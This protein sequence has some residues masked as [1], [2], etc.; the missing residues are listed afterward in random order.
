[1]AQPKCPNCSR[2]FV[3]RVALV[4]TAEMLLGFLYVYPFK[5]QLC[6][7]RFRMPQWGVR[8]VR[9]PEDQRDYDRM[10]ASFPLTFHT[11]NMSGQGAA[12]NISMGGCSFSTSTPLA[13]GMVLRMGLHV[14][15]DLPAVLVD[16]AAVRYVHERTVGIEFLQ[17]Q[18]SERE[19]LQL[20]VRGLLIGRPD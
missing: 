17:W 14:S 6:G 8:Y 10:P 4:G 2:Q 1:M 19:R 13:S 16:A 11:N 5:C 18:E 15:D 7:F 3:R 9:V 12:T 20:F